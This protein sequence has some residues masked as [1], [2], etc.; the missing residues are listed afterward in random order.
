MRPHSVTKGMSGACGGG[1]K[2][3]CGRGSGQARVAGDERGGR[4]PR[5]ITA[6]VENEETQIGLAALE[7]EVGRGAERRVAVIS[8][9]DGRGAVLVDFDGGD[10]KGM[11]LLVAAVSGK[12]GVAVHVRC[13]EIAPKKIAGGR[14]DIDD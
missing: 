2:K 8:R 10:Q 11:N 9:R 12:L 1:G 13:H 14:V 5:L 4:R 3:S 6:L 7:R